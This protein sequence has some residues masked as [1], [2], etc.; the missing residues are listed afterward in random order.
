MAQPGPEGP[1]PSQYGRKI[2]PGKIVDSASMQGREGSFLE[3]GFT[4]KDCFGL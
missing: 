3:M 2:R 1:Y 4:S